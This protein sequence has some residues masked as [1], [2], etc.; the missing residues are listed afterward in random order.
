MSSKGSATDSFSFHQSPDAM[1]AILNKD[2]IKQIWHAYRVP[3]EMVL[4][5]PSLSSRVTLTWEY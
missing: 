5:I 2:D 4:E 1:S 3:D